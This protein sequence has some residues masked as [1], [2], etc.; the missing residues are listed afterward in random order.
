MMGTPVAGAAG[1]GV[2]AAAGSTGGATTAPVEPGKLAMD[3]CGIKTKYSGDEYC[4]LPPP[5][6]K[7]FQMHIGPKD[8]NNVEAKYLLQPGQETT[9]VF[10]TTSSNDEMKYFYYRQF[11]QRPGAHHNIITRG[12]GD[13]GLSPRIGTV[14]VLAE[15]YPKGGIIAPE[16]KGVG[17]GMPAHSTISVSLHSINTSEN[18]ELREVWVNFWYRDAAEVTEP[19]NE[20]FSIAPQ[21]PIAPN[22]DV[23]TNGSCN[24]SG[25]GRLLWAYGHRHANTVQFTMWRNRGGKKDRIYLSYN[26]EEVLL[27]DYSSTVMNP[28]GDEASKTEG[29]WSGVLDL[30]AGDQ[31]TWQCHVVNKQNNTLLFTNNTFTGEMCILDAE[32]VG[33]NCL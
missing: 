20:I 1:G 17:I 2:A 29:G 9:D 32:M 26:W 18:V 16:N 13:I 25:T 4:I 30:K 8:Y 21:Q 7:G 5:A 12:S 23:M 22:A 6:D 28:L 24:V 3:E 27:L 14:N 31:V 15:D 33:A 19:V 10:E 11:R